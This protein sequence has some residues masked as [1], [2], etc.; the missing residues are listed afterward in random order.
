MRYLKSG[1]CIYNL[2]VFPWQKISMS[3][4]VRDRHKTE[5]Y[6]IP[7][8]FDIETTNM[9]PVERTWTDKNGREKKEV[10]EKAYAYMYHWQLCI[11]RYVLF[12]R[13]WEEYITTMDMLSAKLGLGDGCRLVIYVHNLPYEFQFMH[14]FQEIVS[15]FARK[16]RKPMKYVEK[17]GIEWRC[18]YMLSNMSLAKFCENSRN[19]THGKIVGEYDYSKIRTPYTKLT[20][21]EEQYCYND[22]Y[23]L[24]E[25]IRDRLTEDNI[26]TIP[27]TSTGYVRRE[28]R[29]AVLSNSQNRRIFSKTR[30]M[31][32]CY[33]LLKEAFA[34]G[35]THAN[36]RK[37]G[38]TIEHV[39][40]YDITSSYPGVMLRKKFP[41][42]FVKIRDS[43]WSDYYRSGEALLFRVRWLNLRYKRQ[44]GIPYISI[45][46]GRQRSA[47]VNDNGRVLNADT[48]EMTLTD[49]DF[50]IIA[51]MYEWQE[52]YVHDV[53]TAHYDYLPLEFRQT[54]YE[55][56]EQKTML[57]GTE[58]EYEY[59]KSKNRINSAYG[60]MV[61]DIV[62]PEIVYQNGTWSEK[63]VSVEHAIADYYHNKNS[64]LAYQWGVWVTAWA[65]TE[66]Q[67]GIDACGMDIIYVD[68][69]SIKTAKDVSMEIE[70]INAEVIEETE[71]AG[72][73]GSVE[74]NGKNYY[75]GTWEY[76]GTYDE[77]RTLGAKKYVVKENGK[78]KTTVAGLSKSVGAKYIN[79]HGIEAF[80]IGTVFKKCGNLTATYNDE[81]IHDITIDEHTFLTASNLA[82]IDSDYTLGVTQEYWE[83]FG[84]NLKKYE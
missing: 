23:G 82:L 40:S 6:N 65:R 55:Y 62:A 43:K 32:E 64:F 45:S 49:L 51:S 71:S 60:M 78:Y 42:A 58:H 19:V 76:E 4:K 29:K 70:R 12:G 30:P 53:Y 77:F 2:R 46:K 79:E 36:Y 80:A 26:V 21:E 8:A 48:F 27:L 10:I 52:M 81:S 17:R 13:T 73:K 5:Y 25:C 59:M 15:M 24:C 20:D 61:T 67:K 54:L 66:L 3:P 33:I 35:N 18:S 44:A 14:D 83:L 56:F 7:C 75:M 22:V 41:M 72:M 50:K 9:P 74:H 38:Y 47:I 28:F 16:E 84:E 68:T 31:P 37:V 11:D 34:G 63:P 69:D 39:R 57:K 1:D